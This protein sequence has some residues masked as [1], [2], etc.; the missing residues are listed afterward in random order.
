MSKLERVVDA[1][2]SEERESCYGKPRTDR[3]LRQAAAKGGAGGRH[4]SEPRK[5]VIE[6]AWN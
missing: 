5:E 1:V 3:R 2:R 4:C 6:E